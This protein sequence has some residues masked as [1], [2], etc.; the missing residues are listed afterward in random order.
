MDVSMNIHGKSVDMDM[1]IDGKFHIHSK[2]GYK[3]P[4]NVSEIQRLIGQKSQIFSTPFSFS[5]FAR[6]DRFRIYGKALRIL[7]LESSW[8]PTVVI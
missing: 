5:S 6:D 2:P 3:P 4:R 1:D 7:K 8:Q